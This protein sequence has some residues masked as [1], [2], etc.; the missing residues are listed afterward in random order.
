MKIGLSVHSTDESQMESAFLNLTPEEFIDFVK[1]ETNKNEYI[2]IKAP[3]QV[4]CN[5]NNKT[6]DLG[7]EIEY[8]YEL[9]G[10]KIYKIY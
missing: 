9:N 5:G 4:F 7:N 1:I 8:L 6:E 2:S 3:A 10:R